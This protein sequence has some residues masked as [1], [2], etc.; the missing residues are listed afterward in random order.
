MDKDYTFLLQAVPL[1][2]IG[3]I[4]DRLDRDNNTGYFTSNI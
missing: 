4:A 2:I 1:N 3:L